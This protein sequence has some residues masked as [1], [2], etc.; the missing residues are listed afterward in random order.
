VWIGHLRRLD[1]GGSGVDASV[2]LPATQMLDG[3]LNGAPELTEPLCRSVASDR[4]EIQYSRCGDVGTVNVDFSNGAMSTTQCRRL[5]AALRSAAVDDTRVT[6]IGGGETFSNGIHLSVIEAAPDRAAQAWRNINAIDDACQQILTT[7]QIVISSTR[8]PAGAGGV[9]MAPCADIV[10]AH[11]G[12]VLNP[13]YRTMGLFGSEFW[14][15]VL[16]RRIG[17]EHASRLAG[18]C[19][20]VSATETADMGLVDEVIAGERDLFLAAVH[21]RALVLA[22]SLR[23]AHLAAAKPARR[24]ADE[25]RRPLAAYRAFELAEMRRDIRTIATASPPPALFVT[26]QPPRT[27]PAHL[28]AERRLTSSGKRRR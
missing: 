17:D 3:R 10:L 28:V 9:M 7:D 21:E 16:P 11:D 23:H 15:Y 2:K 25:R 26:K 12:I 20:P 6:V 22:G 14:T 24:A 27:T 1:V 5:T 8:E 19:L 18:G 13:H 4:S